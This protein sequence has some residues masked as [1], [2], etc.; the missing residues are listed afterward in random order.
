MNTQN[1]TDSLNTP[2]LTLSGVSKSYGNA[3]EVLSNLNMTFPRGKVVGLLGPNG[4]GKTTL[5]K[6]ICGLHQP[7]SGTIILNG[8]PVG[9]ESKAFISYLPER[10][11]LPNDI[12]VSGLMS[13]FLDFFADFDAVRAENLLTAMG[14]DLNA[15]IKTLSK[16]TKEKIQLI[17]TMSRRSPLYILD[18]P[19]AGVDPAARD[20]IL[21]TIFS[22]KPPESTIILSTHLI[23]DI[24]PVLDDVIFLGRNGVILGGS[25]KELREHYGKNIDQL[26]REVYRV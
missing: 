17:M 13:L 12:S 8:I 3:K 7:T 9:P 10:T 18:E 4:C 20:F 21:D 19:I 23:Y 1:V 16:G 15:R 24:E 22:N 6:L 11:Y 25:A 2:I 14:I 26:F 5:I